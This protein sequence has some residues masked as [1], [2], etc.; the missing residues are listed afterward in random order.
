MS[1]RPGGVPVRAAAALVAVVA[2]VLTVVVAAVLVAA[3]AVALMPSA[4]FAVPHRVLSA[5]EHSVA[6]A[7]HPNGT[8]TAFAFGAEGGVI[9][10]ATSGES[11]HAVTSDGDT[12]NGAVWAA[13]DGLGVTH[14]SGLALRTLPASRARTVSGRTAKYVL[15]PPLGY[16]AARIRYVHTPRLPLTR[17]GLRAVPGSLPGSFLGAP[18]VTAHGALIGAVAKVGARSWEFAPLALLRELASIKH[19]ASTPVA[20]I[21]VGGLIVLLLGAAFGVWRVRHRRDREQDLHARQRRNH[22]REPLAQGPLVRSRT[23][24]EPRQGRDAEDFEVI[25]KPRKEET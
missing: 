22:A 1:A 17:L 3:L 23:P 8:T 10:A 9:T 2:A 16:E 13:R 21:I 11:L 24:S 19:G 5:A 7:Q 15:G 20:T 12:I 25:V 14:I 6:A 4:A 18:V